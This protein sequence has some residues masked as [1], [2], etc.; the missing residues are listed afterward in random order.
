[1][2]DFDDNPDKL[3]EKQKEAVAD[4]TGE[5]P[6]DIPDEI[7]DEVPPESEAA[8]EEFGEVF[9]EAMAAPSDFPDIPDPMMEVPTLEPRT[10]HLQDALED[11]TP[12]P[13]AIAEELKP[14]LKPM[15]EAQAATA[16]HQESTE[17]AV[18]ALAEES[19]KQ[20]ERQ[21]HLI[22]LTDDLTVFT[23]VMIALTAFIAVAMTLQIL[24]IV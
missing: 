20:R 11:M 12:V 10:D 4:L 3:S 24:G 19:K 22:E 17:E 5:D 14:F 9:D 8:I 6:E 23:K 21:E 13:K 18:R 15:L 7:P 16:E 2:N 1:M